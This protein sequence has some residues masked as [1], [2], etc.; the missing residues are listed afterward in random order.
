MS[1]INIEGIVKDIN[2]R[3]TYLTP[4]VDLSGKLGKWCKA[5]HRCLSSTRC[6][7][8]NMVF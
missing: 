5:Y 6:R 1:K 4:L 2:V 3:T 8:S 7:D